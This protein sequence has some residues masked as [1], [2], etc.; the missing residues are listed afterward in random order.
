MVA[1]W[2]KFIILAFKNEVIPMLYPA[3]KDYGRY[4][5]PTDILNFIRN[6]YERN[7]RR[8]EVL[9]R[10]LLRL[11][12]LFIINGIQIINYKGPETACRTRVDTKKCQFN[13]LDFLIHRGQEK[14]VKELLQ[15]AGYRQVGEENKYSKDYKF[16]LEKDKN[17][18]P[19][20]VSLP[21]DVEEYREIIVEPHLYLTE[22]RLPISIDYEAFWQRRQYHYFM[23]KFLPS[24]SENDLLFILCIAGC[25][26]NW[27]NL[28][29]INH[30]AR[31]VRYIPEI[32]IDLCMKFARD[33]GGERMLMM[34]ILL[35][36]E[37]LKVDVFPDVLSYAKSDVEL[38]KQAEIIVRNRSR[39]ISRQSES[40]S[41][42][43]KYSAQIKE[44]LDH[45]KD[46][47]IYVWRTVTL[48][49]PIHRK[50]IPLPQFLHVLYF[51]IVPMHD[52]LLMPAVKLCKKIFYGESMRENPIQLA[53]QKYREN[54][55]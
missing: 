14:N 37:L 12:E 1:D 51:I 21:Q 31:L 49:Y 50:H 39:S 29:L 7:A 23:G 44:T 27:K 26:S 48:P 54:N 47:I 17:G 24:F 10:E 53:L 20:L 32:N 36:R 8:N 43:W 40:Y 25:K 11:N 33:S 41:F 34:G 45:P 2:D 3:L 38:A 22:Y 30:V 9:C 15:V 4:N 19:P 42:A 18:K 5:I 28:K 16:I 6:R 55:K 52:Y 46:R 13:D 35:A